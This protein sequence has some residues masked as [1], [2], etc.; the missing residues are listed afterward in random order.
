[1]SLQDQSRRKRTEVTENGSDDQ[2]EFSAVLAPLVK[3]AVVG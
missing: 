1:M 2:Q 3:A